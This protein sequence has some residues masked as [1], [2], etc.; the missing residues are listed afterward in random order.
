MY[1]TLLYGYAVKNVGDD[2]FFYILA[3]RYPEVH[4]Y[5]ESDYYREGQILHNIHFISKKEGL[6]RHI[7]RRFLNKVVGYCGFLNKRLLKKKFDN[8]VFIG[9]S[10][11]IENK[12]SFFFYDKFRNQH[13]SFFRKPINVIGCNYGPAVSNSFYY[14]VCHFL[15]ATQDVCFRDSKSFNLFKDLP[16]CRIEKDIVFSYK[17][18]KRY[19]DETCIGIS[20]IDL[21]NRDFLE[22]IKF[23]YIEGIISFVEQ[24]LKIGYSVKL[25]S[26]CEHE[27]DLRVCNELMS[28]IQSPKVSIVN[29]DGDLEHFVDVFLS[30]SVIMA[31]R[32]HACVLALSHQ[33]P[34]LPIPYSS[35]ITNMLEDVGF[36]GE[37]VKINECNKLCSINLESLDNSILS[38]TE[39][40]KITESAERQFIYL[41]NFYTK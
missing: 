31:T 26:F 41:D 6:I 33:I 38:S 23:F 21:T 36:R 32:F 12:R 7:L 9:G 24:K 39:L 27:G 4:F 15:G 37:I 10:I 14:S 19:K 11:F 3:N 8:I 34:L 1:N 16:N 22:E 28:R 5:I 25:F 2:L 17:K 18:A 35:K 40:E 30:C 29:Y 20:V 13:K